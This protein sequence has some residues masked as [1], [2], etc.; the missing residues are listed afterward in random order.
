MRGSVI[1][2][3]VVHALVLGAYWLAGVDQASVCLD[4]EAST[5]RRVTFADGV[6]MVVVYALG[7]RGAESAVRLASGVSGGFAAESAHSSW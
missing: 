5:R 2:S 7:Q 3:S 1:A 6:T 4:P